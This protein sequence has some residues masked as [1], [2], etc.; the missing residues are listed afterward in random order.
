M[1]LL[2][3]F[4][5][6]TLAMIFEKDALVI[7]ST[8]EYLKGCSFEHLIISISFCFLGY[9]NGLGKTTFVMTQGLITSFA[10]RIPMSYLLSRLPETGM[11]IIGLAVPISALVSL[12]LNLIYF[13]FL[14]KN[15]Q[16]HA[17]AE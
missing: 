4:A 5:G 2:T 17:S 11:F 12:I 14:E 15:Q 9:F 16:H 10:V 3:Y 7:A 13:T 6:D 1:F 8:A